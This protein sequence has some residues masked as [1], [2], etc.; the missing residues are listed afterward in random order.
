M[1]PHSLELMSEKRS[2]SLRVEGLLE[3]EGGVILSIEHLQEALSDFTHLTIIK[4]ARC[5][6]RSATN[7]LAFEHPGCTGRDR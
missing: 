3:V 1:K 4:H 2:T 6:A 7:T 5:Y